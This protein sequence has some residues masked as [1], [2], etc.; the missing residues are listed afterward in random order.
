M[1]A[2]EQHYFARP[3]VAALNKIAFTLESDN[4]AR[5]VVAKRTESEFRQQALPAHLKVT[6]RR[7]HGKRVSVRGVKNFKISRL[8]LAS[9]PEDGLD[10]MALP[11]LAIVISGQADLLASDYIMHC[12]PG[13][14][15][16]FPAGVPTGTENSNKLGGNSERNCSVL[17]IYPGRLY[18]E[19]LECWITRSQGKKL[20]V[21][22]ENGMALV[23]NRSLAQLFT[24]LCDELSQEPVAKKFIYYFL[25]SFILLL[26]RELDTG[27]GIIPEVRRLHMPVEKTP[28]FVDSVKAYI[29]SNLDNHLTVE[30]LARE[31][32]MS[33][34]S[35]K[36]KFREAMGITFHEYLTNCRAEFAVTLLKNTDLRVEEIAA[37]VGL[38]YDQF[39]KLIAVKYQCTPGELRKSTRCA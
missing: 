37:K 30:I 18:G 28:V 6:S 4:E 29:E 26:H 1:A 13:D 25:L 2:P 23:R 17:R 20:K 10:E 34:T 22:L 5:I 21:S 39:R 7:L 15:V 19:G 3:L 36:R 27:R 14:V 8:V 31:Y 32:I 16:L 35:F 12:Y 38:K 9:W 24:Q 33:P 11:S